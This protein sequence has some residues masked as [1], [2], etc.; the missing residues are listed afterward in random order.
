MIQKPQILL[1]FVMNG[2]AN[3]C[4]KIILLK[5]FPSKLLEWFCNNCYIAGPFVQKSMG[6]LYHQSI[7]KVLLQYL[8]NHRDMLYNLY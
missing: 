5:E 1:F 8:A 2:P 6:F 4:C 7:M 3:S